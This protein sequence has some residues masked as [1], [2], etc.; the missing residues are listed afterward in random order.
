MQKNK[1]KAKKLAAKILAYWIAEAWHDLENDYYRNKLLPSE[2]ELIK[3][4]IHCYGRI[5]SLLLCQRYRPH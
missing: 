1:K 2:R 3:H 5:I 4:Y